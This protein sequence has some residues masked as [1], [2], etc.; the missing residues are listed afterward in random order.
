MTENR[1]QQLTSSSKNALSWAFTRARH[2]ASS[3]ADSAYLVSGVDSV[4]LLVGVCLAHGQDSE[5][6]QL[7]RRLQISLELLCQQLRSEGGFAPRG[8]RICF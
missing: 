1:F 6:V 7:F 3:L 4:Y 5:P 8:T 2:R